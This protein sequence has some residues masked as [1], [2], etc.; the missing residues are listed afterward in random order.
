MGT[1]WKRVPGEPRQAQAPAP[2]LPTA[3]LTPI[4]Q[5][6]RWGAGTQRRVLFRPSPDPDCRQRGRA[7][8]IHRGFPA[9][10]LSKLR[11]DGQRGVRTGPCP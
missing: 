3:A 4:P 11:R 1:A 8:F 2:A 9:L 6:G 7:A 10:V 5:S